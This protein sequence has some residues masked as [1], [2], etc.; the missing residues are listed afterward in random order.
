MCNSSR[1]FSKKMPGDSSRFPPHILSLNSYDSSLPLPITSTP[2]ESERSPASL[3]AGCGSARRW[4]RNRCVPGT[5]T[6]PPLIQTQP[7]S[8]CLFRAPIGQNG[9]GR[10]RRVRLVVPLPYSPVAKCERRRGW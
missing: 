1:K 8:G 7:T 3:E 5:A 9:G 4:L 2:I 6:A 10:W